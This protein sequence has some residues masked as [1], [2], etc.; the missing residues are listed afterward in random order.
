MWNYHSEA[1]MK[2]RCAVHCPEILMAGP[3]QFRDYLRY[4]S[5]SRR[6]ITSLPQQ[7]HV[8]HQ[9]SSGSIHA[10]WSWYASWRSWS[11]TFSSSRLYRYPSRDLDLW[12]LLSQR[13][14]FTMSQI[15][16]VRSATH[17]QLSGEYHE[18]YDSLYKWCNQLQLASGY[19]NMN[20]VIIETQV[21]KWYT[22]QEL[23]ISKIVAKLWRSRHE[24]FRAVY[25]TSWLH[26]CF[27]MVV[28]HSLWY[29]SWYQFLKFGTRKFW[30][31]AT[32]HT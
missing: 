27:W 23:R 18:W 30:V 1:W 17:C 22:S 24:N 5:S 32:R 11:Y 9:V 7:D 20:T 13:R 21:M 26:S 16:S 4:A 25:C 10:S 19:F 28:S 6:N 31:A 15:A 2:S 14:F 29:L 8:S 3:S 12:F